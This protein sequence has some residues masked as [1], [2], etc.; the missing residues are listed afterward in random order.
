MATTYTV[1]PN[2]S[3]CD[4]IVQATGSLDAGIQFCKDNNV[5]ITAIPAV[6]TVFNVSDSSLALGDHGILRKFSQNGIVVGTL[7]AMASPPLPSGIY[8]RSLTIDYTLCGGSDCHDFPVLVSIT[9]ATLRTVANGGHVCRNDGYDILFFKDPGE[10]YELNWEIESYD[11]FSGVLVAWLKLSTISSSSDTIFYMRYGETSITTFHGGAS[12]SVWNSYYRAVY[13]LGSSLTADAT[14]NALTLTN[15]NHVNQAD[16][17]IGGGAMFSSGSFQSMTRDS[18]TGLPVGTA[19]RSMTCWFKMGANQ[20][21]EFLG[22]GNNVGIGTYTRFSFF[23]TGSD[24][25]C[26]EVSGSS[27][28]FAWIYDTN[29]H[30]ITAVLP[31]GAN[32][33]DQVLIYFDGVLQTV[34]SSSA[35]LVTTNTQLAL[36]QIPEYLLDS[37]YTGML[38]EVRIMNTGITADWEKTEYNNQNDP[39]NIGTGGFITYGDEY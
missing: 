5:S 23:Y 9:H 37:F 19:E 29:W 33:L 24:V 20:A 2:Q 39:G 36:G 35:V 12:G 7:D 14:T 10:I 26:L 32:N 11:G 38:D 28:G 6:G 31:A 34:V 8:H 3:M 30:K 22:Y 25:L 13:H 15:H 16:G 17:K 18:P 1:Q 27:A 4:S 21:H